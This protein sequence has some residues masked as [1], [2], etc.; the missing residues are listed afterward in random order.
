V[1]FR[2]EETRTTTERR[3]SSG[4]EQVFL[5]W[6]TAQFGLKKFSAKSCSGGEED[7]TDST[8]G[9]KGENSSAGGGRDMHILKERIQGGLSHYF[10]VSREGEGWGK[11]NIS[12]LGGSHLGEGKM[13][14]NFLVFWGD[15][16]SPSGTLYESRGEQQDDL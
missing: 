7:K 8:R 4:K 16:T 15:T 5:F 3:K 12:S 2:R 14:D 1:P 6:K 10:I 11:S 9:K 13:R